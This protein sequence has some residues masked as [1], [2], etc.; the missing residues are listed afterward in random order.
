MG[1]LNKKSKAQASVYVRCISR[2]IPD[3]QAF[4]KQA[5]WIDFLLQNNL[6]FTFLFKSNFAWILQHHVCAQM[7]VYWISCDSDIPLL[8]LP[9]GNLGSWVLWLFRD[10]S[11]AK[12]GCT[13][14]SET[15]EVECSNTPWDREYGYMQ[16]LFPQIMLSPPSKMD[17]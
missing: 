9:N 15:S 13:Q 11:H 1:F 10:V 5:H 14:R 2:G 7:Q 8:V 3:Q 16:I 6:H 17:Y 4:G 12:L